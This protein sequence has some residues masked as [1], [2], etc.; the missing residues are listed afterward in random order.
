VRRVPR[1]PGALPASLEK[2]ARWAIASHFE[3]IAA[4]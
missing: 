1:G 3:V 4:E 2:L